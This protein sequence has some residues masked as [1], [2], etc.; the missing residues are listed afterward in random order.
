MSNYGPPGGIPPEPPTGGDGTPPPPPPPPAG[1]Y[2]NPPQQPAYG[3]P[4]PQPGGYGA[5][6]PHQAGVPRPGELLDRFLARLIDGVIL[7]VIFGILFAILG[8]ILIQEATYDFEDG[9][10]D[11]G[12]TVLFYIVLSALTSLIY[13]GYYAF[14]ESSRGQTIGKQVVKLKVFGPDGASNPTMEQ[15]IRRNIWMAFGILGVIP[16]I[17]QLIG[18]LAQIAAIV[19]IVVGINADTARRQHWFDKFAGG[20]TVMKVG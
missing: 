5:P 14:L 6:P 18:G 12:S 10:F 2:G 1:G 11:N 15:A 16:V 13:L 3:T 17:G 19:L 9:S 7:G 4:P 20:T 8:A